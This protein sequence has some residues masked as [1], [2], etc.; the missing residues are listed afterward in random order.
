MQAPNDEEILKAKAECRARFGHDRIVRVIVSEPIGTHALMAAFNLREAGVYH[1]ARFGIGVASA[2]SSLVAERCLWPSADALEE[3]RVKRRM[4]AVDVQIETQ[5]RRLMGFVAG[6]AHAMPLSA[7]TA[8]PSF[9]AGATGK[10]AAAKVAQ[11]Q[12]QYAG[13]QLWSIY[14]A[15]NGLELIMRSPTSDVWTAASVA[16]SAAQESNNGRLTCVLDFARDHI[17]WSPKP[18]DAYFDEAPGRA[19]D[20]ASPFFEMGGSGASASASFL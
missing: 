8:P 11:L 18:I 1:D 14:R 13:E 10:E 3:I 20:C 15:E 2:R 17:V 19:D 4:P 9:A 16:A 12:A 5:F 7:A 6:I